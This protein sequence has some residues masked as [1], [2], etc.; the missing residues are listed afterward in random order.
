MSNIM[1]YFATDEPV[2]ASNSASVD[3]APDDGEFKNVTGLVLG[4]NDSFHNIEMGFKNPESPSREPS[5]SHDPSEINDYISEVKNRLKSQKSGG[6]TPVK[7]EQ[8]VST[9]SRDP[10]KRFN[11]EDFSYSADSHD[12][13]QNKKETTNG[14]RRQPS[15]PILNHLI[16]TLSDVDASEALPEDEPTAAQ[17]IEGVD[18]GIA[19]MMESVP[20]NFDKPK[21]SPRLSENIARAKPRDNEK[22]IPV[23]QEHGVDEQ[24]MAVISAKKKNK[25]KADSYLDEFPVVKAGKKPS[26]SSQADHDPLDMKNRQPKK[27]KSNDSYLSEFAVVKVSDGPKSPRPG[28]LHY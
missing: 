1:E 9:R 27:K 20:S 13:P 28:I 25:K 6:E 15:S 3:I 14:Y 23:D 24:D 11:S 2:E 26:E 7:E 12:S 5:L 16:D 4:R 18:Q 22:H 8:D 19:D 21:F 10:T 17:K